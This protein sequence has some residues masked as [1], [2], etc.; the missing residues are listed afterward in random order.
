[1]FSTSISP[2]QLSSSTVA[3]LNLGIITSTLPLSKDDNPSGERV[4]VPGGG[5]DPGPVNPDYGITEKPLTL[6]GLA[7]GPTP[8]SDAPSDSD[9]AQ[10]FQ[11]FM[12]W[13]R[14]DHSQTD[15]PKDDKQ[16]A[17]SSDVTAGKYTVSG[18][19]ADRNHTGA[20]I[21]KKVDDTKYKTGND[22]ITEEHG[23]GP[24]V[25]DF[26]GKTYGYVDETK[27]AAIQVGNKIYS[28]Y[29]NPEGYAKARSS[30]ETWDMIND[31]SSWKL[32]SDQQDNWGQAKERVKDGKESGKAD[33][34][35]YSLKRSGDVDNVYHA[36]QSKE[37]EAKGLVAYTDNNNHHYVV[38]EELNPEAYR[39]AREYVNPKPD[40][41]KKDY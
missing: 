20:V 19:E 22:K 29:S 18:D 15:A 3:P 25:A 2:H 40:E 9:M 5:I 32:P 34:G 1:M 26:Q 28:A 27:E 8:S 12:D 13:M 31:P 37:M 24:G 36:M 6:A 4:P 35:D 11:K 10:L 16:P 33:A 39:K 23:T 41:T 17:V 21:S 38:S 7:T 14:S 30:K